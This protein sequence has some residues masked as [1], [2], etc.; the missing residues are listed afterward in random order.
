MMAMPGIIK[1]IDAYTLTPFLSIARISR[2]NSKSSA[3]KPRIFGGAHLV[4]PACGFLPMYI[5]LIKNLG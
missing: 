1:F 4:K 5:D 3:T 2:C